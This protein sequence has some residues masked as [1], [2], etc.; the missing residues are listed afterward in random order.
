MKSN[1]KIANV[2]ALA[3][4]IL[5]GCT[6]QG[7]PTEATQTTE[8][9]QPT[10]PPATETSPPEPTQELF[11]SPRPGYIAFDFV[12][13][14][15]DAT[16]SNSGLYLPCPGDSFVD[17]EG[18]VLLLD[19]A[20]IASG[21]TVELPSLLTVVPQQ[22]GFGGI[23][24]HYPAFTVQ[25]GDQF[26]T[27]LACMHTGKACD[28]DFE[29][30]YFDTSGTFRSLNFGTTPWAFGEISTSGTPYLI[31]E[32]DLSPL[33]GQTVEF[34]LVVRDQDGESSDLAVWIAPYI[35]RDPAQTSS[36][37][38]PTPTFRPPS[39]TEASD[40]TPG[41]ISGVVDMSSAPPYLN[42]PMLGGSGTPVVVVFFNLDD[43]T[44]WWYH[45]APTHPNFQ[46]TVTPGR[47]QIV[48]YAPGVGGV[49]YVA[50][51]YTGSNPS[52]GLPLAE[53][54]VAPNGTVSGIQIADWNWTCGG[55]AYRPPKPAD[56]PNP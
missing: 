47:Y 9:A 15:C 6:F 25:S 42:D 2:V 13:R 7:Q 54:T 23:F 14:M 17:D 24:G 4:L 20:M 12:A 26:R 5:A 37:P 28:V 16:W 46:M 51:G 18:Y 40:S 52:C 3:S 27:I 43:S 39:P 38:I 35:W 45:T 56:V 34:T 49:P 53:I 36:T 41:V 1:Q 8:E 44:Y 48:A 10:E 30:Q 19:T 22:S 55:T 29:L 50:A 11:A 33:A 21:L 31:I 32:E